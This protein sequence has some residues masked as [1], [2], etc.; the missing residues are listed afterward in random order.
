MAKPTTSTKASWAEYDHVLVQLDQ[1]KQR[2][3]NTSTSE[4]AKLLGESMGSLKKVQTEWVRAACVAKGLPF[5][6]VGAGEEWGNG[7]LSLMRNLKLLKEA[8]EAGGTPNVLGVKPHPISGQLQVK[9]FPTN[10]YDSLMVKGMEAEV[11]LKPGAGLSTGSLYRKKRHRKVGD[12]IGAGRVSLILG[13]G[14]V[15]SIAPTDALYKLFMEDEVVVVKAN[16]VNAYL[17][18]FWEEALR[19]F[20]AEGFIRFVRGGKEAGAYLC[21]HPL[22]ETLHITGSDKTHDAIVWANSAKT[23][24]KNPRPIS[25]E[26]GA[27]SP[28]IVVPGNWSNSDIEYHARNV[29]SMIVNN[30]S[31]NCNAGKVLI[32]HA[33]WPLRKHFLDALEAVLKRTPTKKA[34]YPGAHDRHKAFLKEYPQHTVCSSKPQV[35]V[36][37]EETVPWVILNNVGTSENE[38][39]LTH[40]AFCGVIA[41]VPLEAEDLHRY[42]SKAVAFANEKCWGTLS[43]TMIISP[44]SEDALGETFTRGLLDL[45]YGTI[46]INVWAGVCFAL[47]SPAW[48]AFP[49][50]TLEDI[51]SGIGVVHN[52]YL[53]D[54]VERS[55]LRAPFR[56]WPT[57]LW[58][59]DHKTAHKVIPKL[60][61]LEYERSLLKLP[62]IAALAL[63]G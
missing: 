55:V 1:N 28:V 62:S 42:F 32:T 48:G 37:S 5:D 6:G 61:D 36:Q 33:Q 23:I 15:S 59:T 22:V 11:W 53:L 35:G 52:S 30:A 39:A 13:A 8:M 21:D 58:F 9:V 2:W 7:P 63:R 47:V 54:H 10:A 50:H 57:P 24:R 41:D 27:V 25:S 17:I 31:F 60:V 49:G 45:H 34:Y 56:V 16:P 4:R 12:P 43:G 40:E 46:G 14:N 38:Y 3:V 26:L 44:D 18:P 20:V 29:A 51:K 19:P